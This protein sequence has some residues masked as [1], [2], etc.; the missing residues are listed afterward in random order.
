MTETKTYIELLSPGTLFA[1][2]FTKE[3]ATR[4][5][6]T[7]LPPGVFAWRFFDRTQVQ[8]NG[9]TL[10]GKPHN[11]SGYT[12]I[13]E[14]F[15]LEQVK[16]RFPDAQILIFNMEANGWTTVVRTQLGN[17]CPLEDGDRVFS[18]V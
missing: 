13:G 16:R 5:D 9:E 17:F 7:E 11:F 10:T 15:T 12:Y 8:L 3:V 2:T 6:P 4:R 18:H 1:E 14:K